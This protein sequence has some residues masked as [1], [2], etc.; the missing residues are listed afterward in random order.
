MIN[1]TL[2]DNSKIEIED[3]STVLDVAKKIGEGLA[4]AAIAGKINGKLVDLSENIK[5]D[6]E[7][8]IITFKDD[9]GKDIFRHSSSHILAAAVK[10]LYPKVKLGIGP[11][12]EDGFYY[13]FEKE[14]PFTPEDLEKIESEMKKIIKEDIK[15]QREEISKKEA[16]EL[17]KDEKYKLELLEELDN[18]SIYKLENFVDLCKGPHVPSTKY[19]TAFKLTKFSGAYWKGDSDNTQMQRI[20]GVSFPD[21]KQLKSYLHLLE[22]AEKRNH[23]KL[24]REL[25]LFSIHEEGP[26]FPFFHPKGMILWNSLLDYWKEEHDNAEY[27]QIKTPIILNRNLWETSGHW[28]NYKENMY[29]LKIDK[30]D[31]AIKPMNCPGGMLLYKEK[32]HSYKEFPMRVAEIG[33]VHRHEM[34]GAL[35][36]LFRVRCFHQ[37]DA[38]IFMTE[39]QIKDEIL[40]VLNLIDNVYKTFG[41]EYHLE[42][43]TRPDKSIG[44]DDQWEIATKGLKSA[45]DSTNKEYV[46][47]EGDGAFYGP[48]IDIHIKDS[49]KRTWQC[50]T[51]Q[52]DMSLP[53][54]FNLTYEGKDGKKHR[55][56]M[57]HRVIY[58]SIERFTGILIE[59]FAGWFPLWLTPTQVRVIAVSDKFN[60][61]AKKIVSELKSKGIRVDFD[62]RAETTGKKIRDSQIEKIPIVINIGEKEAENDTLAVRTNKDGKVKFKVKIDELSNKILENIKNKDLE[63]IL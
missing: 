55:P 47:N 20:Y 57:I 52:L 53:E 24:G 16:K 34:S 7:I 37:D 18:P 59:H 17:F 10:R 31:Y 23:V 62:N 14:E 13:D 2:P 41:L 60:D 36:G 9:E 22:E 40:G 6:S 28:E 29:T 3:N 11:A 8:S 19:I 50:G 30:Q 58:G 32:V 54:R 26:G 4:R 1:I 33:L 56:V 45:L 21:K 49:L 46:I 25:D 35:N 5:E 48:K 15:F 43:S 42:L 38:H 39:D 51:I 27:V 63:F 61:H 44:S 12:I